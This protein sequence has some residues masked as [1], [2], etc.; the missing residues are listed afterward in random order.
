MFGSIKDYSVLTKY[1]SPI[2]NVNEVINLCNKILEEENIT[3]FLLELDLSDKNFLSFMSFEQ[4]DYYL[5]KHFFR[6]IA[7]IKWSEMEK[8]DLNKL[9]INNAA[10]YFLFKKIAKDNIALKLMYKYGWQL[11]STHTIY[12]HLHSKIINVILNSIHINQSEMIDWHFIEQLKHIETSWI[13]MLN[14]NLYSIMSSL[15]TKE[16]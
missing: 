13:N 16:I 8:E 10:L 3:N 14:D 12:V 9:Y 15:Q 7:E 2:S 5:F 1:H 6:N 4:L 11:N